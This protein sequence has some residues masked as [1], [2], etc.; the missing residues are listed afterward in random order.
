MCNVYSMYSYEPKRTN[1]S[2]PLGW[3][4]GNAANPMTK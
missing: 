4:W 2:V 1:N 3:C